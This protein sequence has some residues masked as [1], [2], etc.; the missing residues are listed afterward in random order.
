[1]ALCNKHRG[2]V[3]DNIDPAQLGRLTVDV[4]GV[5]T[6]PAIAMPC[7]PYAGPGVGFFALPPIGANVWVEFENDNLD[8]PIWS[9]CFWGQGDVPTGAGLPEIKMIKTAGVTLTMDD[10][11]GNGG[12]SLVVDSSLAGAPLTLSVNATGITIDNGRGAIIK[13]VGPTVTIN[14]GV[15]VVI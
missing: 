13:M 8:L 14:N 11:P 3:V 9:G 5:L 7:V 1:M 6:S 12:F 15:L 10:G 2:I 4:P